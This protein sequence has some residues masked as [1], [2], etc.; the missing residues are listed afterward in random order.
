MK[1][2]MFSSA[3]FFGMAAYAILVGILVSVGLVAPPNE[4]ILFWTGVGLAI[5]ALTIALAGESAR[6]RG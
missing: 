5:I 2:W 6:R 4:E 3:V 1:T